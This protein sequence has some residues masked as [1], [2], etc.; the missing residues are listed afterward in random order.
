MNIQ[1]SLLLL[2]LLLSSKVI[3]SFPQLNALD[4]DVSPISTSDLRNGDNCGASADDVDSSLSRS[5]NLASQ[6]DDPSD[7][8]KSAVGND[9]SEPKDIVLQNDFSEP[10]N[11]ASKNCIPE[12]E[13]VS[14]QEDSSGSFL[15]K[16][17]VINRRL[18]DDTRDFQSSSRS[19]PAQIKITPPSI[20][21]NLPPSSPVDAKSGTTDRDD[22][23]RIDQKTK[24]CEVATA[25]LV[26]S[27]ACKATADNHLVTLELIKMVGSIA[28][29][30]ISNIKG[31]GVFFWFARLKPSHVAQLAKFKAVRGVAPDGKIEYYGTTGKPA[32]P[33]SKSRLRKRDVV[34]TRSNRGSDLSH[35]STAPHRRSDHK[36]YTFFKSAGQATIEGTQR[37][38]VAYVL[39][40]GVN[41]YNYDI[42]RLPTVLGSRKSVI[43][44]WLY[45]RGA[46]KRKTIEAS[47]RHLTTC[48]IS[49]IAGVLY[50]VA[51]EADIIMVK[52][53]NDIS[54]FLDGLIEI[55]SDI[56][57]GNQQAAGF[58]VVSISQSWKNPTEIN[59][60]A[61]KRL[62]K[63][64]EGLGVVIVCAA[65]KIEQEGM[66][67]NSYPAL[68]SQRSDMSIITVGSIDQFTETTPYWSPTGDAVTVSA[69]GFCDCATSDPGQGITKALG[70]SVSASLVTGMLL[71]FA[72]LEDVGPKIRSYQNIPKAFKAYLLR[73]A[74]VRRGASALAV[75]NGLSAEISDQW[76]PDADNLVEDDSPP[77]GDSL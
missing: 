71:A 30:Y 74:Y 26:Y 34:V 46:V 10:N 70:T 5:E 2:Q 40:D 72:A 20:Q 7:N 76:I 63:T 9:S 1:I 35:I 61:M 33:A 38:T 4:S 51:S 77:D 36:T 55:I 56:G 21:P 29:V 37:R 50:G 17:S 59:L 12:S 73:K 66:P 24:R 16:V 6:D 45:A 22:E 23:C 68:W 14:V 65:G 57:F 13:N 19:C 32:Q 3:L 58:T 69:P 18:I 54:S 25:M 27:K 39:G 44:W 47:D 28:R 75:W 52:I 43:N 48:L 31:C 11:I 53:T 62:I 42:L 60:A 64:L 15:P 67:V 41:E 8:G 49:K